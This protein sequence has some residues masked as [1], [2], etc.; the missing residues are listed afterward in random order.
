M[1]TIENEFINES[2]KRLKENTPKIEKCLDELDESEIWQRP[3]GS[4][5]SIGNIIVH[6]CGNITQYILS[7]LGNVEDKRER[8]REFSIQGGL[9]KKELL[10]KLASTVDQATRV[11]QN[12]DPHD[13][14]S[15]RS[16]QGFDL[17]AVGIIIHVV[18]HYS[19]H[20]GQI[21]FWTKLL[22]D[23]DLGFY[24]GIDLNKKN[25]VIDQTT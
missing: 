11:I 4:S 1:E 24:T 13:L 18:E 8:D 21:I 17:S 16:V 3:N 23:K 10:E 22:K 14:L 15:K 12:V 2:I 7:S 5:N 25:V 19:Y 6:L 9:N 20:T